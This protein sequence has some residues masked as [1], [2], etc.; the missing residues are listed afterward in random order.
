MTLLSQLVRAPCVTC[1]HD[2]LIVA[3]KCS[4]CDTVQPYAVTLYVTPKGRSMIEAWQKG[5]E[6]TSA[7]PPLTD[8]Q[9]EAARLRQRKRRA[10]LKAQA[11]R[12]SQQRA[13]QVGA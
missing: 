1:H 4:E 5:R 2:T 8:K 9:T 13:Q 3:G 6:R 10:M 12:A 11:E 7:R